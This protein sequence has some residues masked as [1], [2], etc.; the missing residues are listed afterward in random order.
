M[1]SFIL[2]YLAFQSVD[3]QRPWWR[4]FQK[5]IM[6]ITLDTYFSI[7]FVCRSFG[8]N[9]LLPSVDIAD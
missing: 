9:T 6:C 8:F 2:H 1:T 5:C 7:H 3:L 4:L